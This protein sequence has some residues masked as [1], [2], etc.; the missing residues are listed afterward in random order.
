MRR[1]E[2][3]SSALLR[4][5]EYWTLALGAAGALAAG[6]HW[7]WLAGGGVAGGAVISWLN[8]RWLKQGVI[9]LTAASLQ[10]AGAEKVRVPKT[11]YVK[12]V[13]RFVLILAILYVILSR[14]GRL[15]VAVL[16]GLFALVAGVLAAMIAHLLRNLL[17]A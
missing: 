12:F 4:H 16:S 6:L 2:D 13:G 14:F 15:D 17:Q 9:S 10:Q 8:Y 5:V 11:V 1:V 3:V 7:G